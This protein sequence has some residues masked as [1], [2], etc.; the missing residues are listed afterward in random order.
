MRVMKT[1][2][3]VDLNITSK[4]NLTCLYCSHFTGATDVK[5]D[6]PFAEWRRFMEELSRCAVMEVKLSGGEPLLHNDFDAIVECIVKNRMRFT[7]LSNGT[8]IT[9]EKAKFLASTGRCNFVQLSIDGAKAKTHD[10]CRGKGNFA[11]TVEG[12]CN[13]R[14]YNVN[15]AVRVTIHKYNVGELEEIA[16]FLLEEL[17]LPCFSVNSAGYMGLCR[18]NADRIQLNAAERTLA[19]ETLLRMDKQYRGRISALAGPLAE[20]R[21][22]LEMEMARKEGKERLPQ[23]GYLSGCGHVWS[24]LSVRPDGVIVPCTQMAH[25]ELGRMNQ[26][27]LATVW[28][29]HPELARLRQRSAIPLSNFA[30]CRD[31]SYINYCTGNCPAIAYTMLEDEYQPSPD[32]CFKRFLADGGKLPRQ[33]YDQQKQFFTKE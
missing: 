14:K 1:P 10:S 22:W 7:I 12:F 26:V 3:A 8:L 28:Q 30:Y 9:E 32:A 27:D 5:T 24:T 6:L 2:R 33:L 29:T 23:G 19:M 15:V 13:L 25:I 21:H 16:R 17:E 31:C 18:Q 11:K 4:C 20:A